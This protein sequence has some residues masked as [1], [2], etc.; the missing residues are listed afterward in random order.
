MKPLDVGKYE[1]L[2]TEGK[3][4]AQIHAAALADGVGQIEQIRLLRR[5][6]GLDLLQAKEIT[7]QAE[8]YE[9]LNDFEE[10]V[11]L[12]SVLQLIEL[13]EIEANETLENNN[14]S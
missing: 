10:K 12:P 2:K 11:I 13:D 8:G 1:K 3:T 7:V 9:S 14:H 5:L 4:A 6:F